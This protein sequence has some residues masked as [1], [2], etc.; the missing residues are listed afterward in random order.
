VTGFDRLD[1]EVV[2]QLLHPEGVAV[3]GGIDRSATEAAT[4]AR[5]DALYGAGNWHLVSPKGGDIGSLPVHETLDAVPG[6]VDLAI[7][8]TPP[9]VCPQVVEQCGARGI[10]HVV[11]FSSGFRE[12][13]GRG[14]EIEEQLAAAGRRNGVRILG[15][16][17]N[18]NAFEPQPEIP[19][20]RHGKIG[21]V[22]QSGHNGR[23]IVQGSE[24]G[25]AFSR[26]VPCGN[27]VDLDV[28]D[29]I[30]YF[31]HD[32]DTAV[33][34]GYIEG[35]RSVGKLRAALQACNDAGKPVVLL[36]I[37][38]TEAG[39]TM[40]Q[41][42]TG[43]LT[44]ADALVDSLFEQHGVVRVRDLDELLETAAL[45]AKV[46]GGTG[47]NVALYSI[48][49]GS[50][51]LMAEQAQLAGLSVP[52]L[53]AVTQERLRRHLPDYLTVRNPVDNGGTFIM[54][55]GPEARRD[56]LHAILDDPGVDV[57]VVGITGAMGLTGDPLCEDL[58][59]MAAQGLPKPV[60]TTWNSPKVDER[61][62]ELLIESQLPMFRS[63]RN[64]FA[65][66]R[67][68]SDRQE[69]VARLRH[70][71]PQRPE[72][73]PAAGAA[74]AG[75]EGAPA[76]VL[77]ADRARRLLDAAGI[78]HAAEQVVT[79]AA[80][81]VAAATAIGFPVALK[82]ASPDIPHKSDGGLVRLDVA[83]PDAVRRA[84]DELRDRAATAQPEARVDGVL[85]QAMVAGGQEMIVGIT[86]DPTLGHALLVGLGGV[87]A[88]VLA[89][90][91]VRL[92]PVD[93]HDVRDMVR[94]LACF[95]LLDGARGRPKLAVDAL[96]ATAMATARLAAGLGDRLVELDLNPVVVTADAAVAVDALVVLDEPR[97]DAAVATAPPAPAAAVP[98]RT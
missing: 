84:H 63:F 42:H 53:S 93:E 97:A 46:P 16:N 32:P 11:V 65:A 22:T 59:D 30:H 45:L 61:G 57:L 43:H 89:D 34:A 8:T 2:H 1:H 73:A 14:V 4:R 56:V 68:V 70:R 3:V 76:G 86:R 18:T 40:A 12:V 62:Y 54:R 55:A 21:V 7:L 81:A 91:A 50:G 92:L 49:G 39:A 13:G 47:P 15:P 23:P 94:S 96:V 69:R 74:A 83:T 58:R 79:D 35:F 5:Y 48:S 38:A 71:P 78:R 72:A 87:Y 60:V 28:C 10:R 41:S 98:E 25:I 9:E 85:V 82:I 24:I 19:G 20:Y 67:R 27:E 44:G 33:V 95:P 29:F 52:E 37:G 36:K 26:Q 66:L 64:C 75:V 77:D 88:E 31:A 80:G 90:T 17:T 6:R 51:T